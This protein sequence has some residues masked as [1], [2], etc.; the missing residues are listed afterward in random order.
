MI[1]FPSEDDRLWARAAAMDTIRSCRPDDLQLREDMAAH[2]D[3][4]HPP[5][6][7]TPPDPEQ[8]RLLA[9][10]DETESRLDEA[11]DE[12]DNATARGDKAMEL[13]WR[14]RWSIAL[15]DNE[16]AWDDFDNYT[17]GKQPTE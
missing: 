14:K 17:T 7:E 2:F 12:M 6:A 3:L 16:A 5:L 8:G 4:L 9:V 15:D 1:I 10:V 11:E 13:E